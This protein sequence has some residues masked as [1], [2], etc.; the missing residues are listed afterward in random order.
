MPN[1][2]SKNSDKTSSVHQHNHLDLIYP[3]YRNKF[4]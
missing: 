4:L 3:I 2:N 1:N